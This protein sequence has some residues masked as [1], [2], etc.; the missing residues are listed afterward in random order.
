M[1]PTVEEVM[2][3][4]V[5]QMIAGSALPIEQD[6]TSILDDRFHDSFQERLNTAGSWA[7]D[8]QNVLNAARQV[9]VIATAIASIQRKTKVTREILDAATDVVQDQCHLGFHEGQWCS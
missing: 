1:N 4:L 2:I 9:G 7:R 5:Q 3:Q 6:A 8:G